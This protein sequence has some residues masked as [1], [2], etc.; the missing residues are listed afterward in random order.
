MCWT[1]L[2]SEKICF[3][4]ERADKVKK[5]I[6]IYPA[7]QSNISQQAEIISNKDIII[8]SLDTE[9]KALKK[10]IPSERKKRVQRGFIIGGTLYTLSDIVITVL[11]I[12]FGVKY[13]GL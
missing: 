10:Q 13:G 6:L 3:E 1:A 2:S 4:G 11:A 5:L 12:I 9:N 8:L 7:M